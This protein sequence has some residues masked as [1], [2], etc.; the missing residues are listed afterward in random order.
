MLSTVRDLVGKSITAVDGPIGSVHS[1][2]FD[3]AT[4]AIRYIVVGCGKWLPGRRI[5]LSPM[6][7]ESPD[8]DL[9]VADGI[10]V[11]LDRQ[12]IKNSPDIDADQ[13]VSWQMAARFQEYYG[14]L[15]Y[16]TDAAHWDADLYPGGS[17]WGTRRTPDEWAGAHHAR[18]EKEGAGD[19]QLRSTSEVA[20]FHLVATDGEIGH[21]A[22]VIVDDE[23][24]TI[25]RL[26]VDTSNWPGGR[27][28]LV[29]PARVRSID[30]KTSK[31]LVDITRERV[32][33]SPRFLARDIV[34][35][36]PCGS[37]GNSNDV[38]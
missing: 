26:I 23:P 31:L 29:S 13:P 16:R 38:A 19:S 15:P 33:K 3:D 12:K 24:W 17:A 11:T 9:P 10:R 18:D 25:W 21:V 28:V 36:A 2:L 6:S 5:L 1:L 8:P 27:S 35:H 34:E 4:W 22:D 32:R 14:Y 30:W 20:G 7:A 37:S